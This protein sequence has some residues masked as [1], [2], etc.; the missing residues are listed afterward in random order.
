MALGIPETPKATGNL[1]DADDDDRILGPMEPVRKEQQ[2]SGNL[3]DDAEEDEE[4]A[5]RRL[6]GGAPSPSKMRSYW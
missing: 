5:K 2:A 1:V 4:T 3:V 6:L